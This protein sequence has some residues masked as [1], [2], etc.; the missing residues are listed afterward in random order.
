MS[1]YALLPLVATIAYIPLLATTLSSRPWQRR[2]EL[3]ILFL[4]P[5]MTW[6]LIDYIFR[7]IFFPQ[8]SLLLFEL[9]II[10]FSVTAVQFHFF[11]SSFYTPGQGRWLPFA[12]VS[13]AAII[14]LVMSGYVTGDITTSGDK[15]HGSYRIGILVVFVPMMTLAGRNFYVFLKKLKILDNPIVYNQIVSLLISLA[16]MV[17]FT[18]TALLPWGKEFPLPHIGNLIIAFILSYAVISHRLVDIKLVLRRGLAWTSLGIIGAVSYWLLLSFLHILFDFKLDL[19]AMFAATLVATLVAIFIY[20]MRSFFFSI[21]GRAFQ[22]QSYDYRQGLSDF[23]NKIHNVFSLDEQ[24]GE[25]LT[26]VTKA[27]GC[28][29]AC[30]LFPETANEDFTAQLVEPDEPSNPL[31]RLSLRGQNP[32]IEYLRREQ[33]LLTKENLAVLPEFGGLWEQE[34]LE[35]RTSDIELFMPLISRDRLIGILVLDK[36]QSGRYSIEDYILL[37]DI[38]NRV[39]VSMEKEYLR[40][41]IKEREEELS[42][43]NRSSAIIASSLD[44]QEIYDSFIEELKKIVDLSWAAIVLIQ[45][46]DL[47]FLALSSEIGSAWKVGDRVSIKGTAVERIATRKKVLVEPDLTK[48]ARFRTGKYHIQ[49]GVRSIVYLPLIVKDEVIGSLIV[50]N[51]HPNAYN[52]KHIRLLEQLASQIAMPVE[53]S[54]LYAEVEEKARIDEL[55]GL[56]NRRSLNELVASEI[57]RNSRYGGVFSLIILDLDLFKTFNDN[58]GHLAGDKFLREIGNAIK[59]GIR[60]SDQAFRYGGDEFAILLPQTNF[61]AAYQ[62]AERVRNRIASEIEAGDLVITASLGLAVWPINGI[63]TDE[64]IAAA[65]AALYRAK[66]GGRNQTYRTP[67]TLAPIDNTVMRADKTDDRETLNTIY[68]LPA[69]VDIKDHYTRSHSKMVSEYVIALAEALNLETLEINRL[70]TCALLHDIGKIGI[71]DEILNKTGKLSAEEWKIMKVHPQLGATIVSHS[72]RLAPCIDGILHHHEKYD[73]SGYPGGLR[74]E[75]IPLAARILTIAD[76]FAAMIS[77]R[78]YSKAISHEEA[79]EEIKRGSGKQYDPHLI[80]VFLSVIKAPPFTT[81]RE[82]AQGGNIT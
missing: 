67:V 46:K 74:G 76:A 2:H 53:N 18:L 9:I 64:L 78:P 31:S 38:T 80:E 58:Y 82:E 49:Q 48:K 75:E 73:G 11:I 36:K 57:G 37:E 3:F 40:E 77:D 54:Q 63:S 62:V 4:I 7:S 44:I 66:E 60:D 25:L 61:E 43:I 21:M 1:I 28:Q 17:V 35:I 13:L 69:T 19:R 71:S 30:L 33:K 10:A 56:L 79:A 29:H 50:A 45:N 14:A 51:R 39:A 27:I 65:D 32:I 8:Y 16:A 42:V 81:T 34:K 55:T 5:A 6:S 70:E 24:G 22:G 72:H 59:K 47:Y 20:R 41:Q 23:A 68:S 52:Q 12:Y 26:L 15:I